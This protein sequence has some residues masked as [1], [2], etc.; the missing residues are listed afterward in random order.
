MAEPRRS[1][2]TLAI[3]FGLLSSLTFLYLAFRRI[4]LHGVG[5]ALMHSDW[6]PWYVIAPFVYYAGHIAR[7]QRCRTILEPHCEISLMTG[8][9][10]TIIGYAANNLLPARMGEVV[11]AYVLGRRAN[12]SVSL[13]LAV[14]FLERI[15]DGLSITFILVIAGYFAPLP[16]W[17]K[18]VVTVA[19]TV[20]A[21]ASVAVALL[22]AARPLVRRV[23]AMV[24][25][26]LPENIARRLLGILDRAFGATDC[27]RSPRIL[28]MV[29]L[30]S[31]AAWACEGSM[32]L[33]VLPAFGL[34]MNPLW[35]A[36]ALSISNLATL[37][38]SSPGYI[39]PFHYFCM[40]A[41][42]I[43]GVPQ[44]TALGYAIMVHLLFYIPVTIYGLV[45]LT[46]YGISLGK[47]VESQSNPPG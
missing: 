24:T 25:S 19:L 9:N 45:A 29:L 6:W 42:R 13:A 2:R 33:I 16:E 47:A 31:L 32:F 17:G 35:A 5:D 39:G 7:G 40:Q 18:H 11:R 44:E 46:S 34:P 30:L 22:T 21:G 38:P 4:D 12:V 26:V 28:F 3:A 23:A 36:L 10:C 8:V 1:R 41:I 43:F 15:F 27:L 14:T 20:F 37:V